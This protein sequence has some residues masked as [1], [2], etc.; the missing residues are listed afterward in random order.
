MTDSLSAPPNDFIVTAQ[1]VRAAGFCVVPGLKDFLES[2]GHSLKDFIRQGLPAQTL[3]DF[4]DAQADRAVLKA[5]E[6]LHL[7]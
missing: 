1:D 4:N 2:R 5:M 6:R 3:R 7:G